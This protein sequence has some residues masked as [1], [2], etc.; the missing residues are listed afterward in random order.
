MADDEPLYEVVAGELAR[1]EVRQGLWV[2]A[3]ASSDYEERKAK[4]VYIR[5]RVNSLK[6]ELS[7]A[8]AQ[9]RQRQRARIQYQRN[10]EHERRLQELDTRVAALA[11]LAESRNRIR[12][13][14]FWAG[15][16]AGVLS[17]FVAHL[18]APRSNDGAVDLAMFVLVG[19]VGGPL[20]WSVGSVARW[21]MPSQRRL[22]REEREIKELRAKLTT[23]PIQ[24]FLETAVGW[25]VSSAVLGFFLLKYL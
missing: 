3:L 23:D 1:G 21:L 20:G 24:R 25:L 7:D 19:S 14:A 12:R 17:A 9:A 10:A 13:F 6:Q 22:D 4:A 15:L 16:A 11:P 2:K 5:L 8:L 18:S